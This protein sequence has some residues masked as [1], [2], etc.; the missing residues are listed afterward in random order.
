[1]RNYKLLPAC[2]D[3]MEYFRLETLMAVDFVAIGSDCVG[4]HLHGLN[5]NCEELGLE[6]DEGSLVRIIRGCVGNED[7]FAP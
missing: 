7:S 5:E 1:M 6:A 3:T 4:E 2:A